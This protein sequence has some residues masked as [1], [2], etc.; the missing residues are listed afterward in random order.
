MNKVK[1]FFRDMFLFP[2]PLTLAVL[3]P[4]QNKPKIRWYDKDFNLIHTS[5]E[6]PE[7]MVVDLNGQRFSYKIEYVHND[8]YI[9]HVLTYDNPLLEDV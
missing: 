9:H 4:P 6:V 7:H 5:E 3:K 1:Q 8:Q 2:D